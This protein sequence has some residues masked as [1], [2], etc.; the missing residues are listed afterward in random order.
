MGTT[1]IKA[2]PN[3]PFVDMSRTFDAPRDLI[4]RAHT[5]PELLVQW[6]GP[7]KYEMTVERMDVRD[8]GV[9]RYT[10]RDDQ[11]NA[12]GFHGVFHGDP[13]PDGMT[14]TFEFDGAPGHVSLNTTNVYAEVD[15][16]MKAKALAIC[17]VRG[18]AAKRHW[19]NDV[20]L[21]EFLRN[22]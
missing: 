11:G 12:F 2:E 7:R 5:D 9:W 17:E 3:V 16:E 10:H 20:T 13:S 15:M 21:M 1:Q 19:K 6:L 22:L 18:P 4:F 8:G 14:Q